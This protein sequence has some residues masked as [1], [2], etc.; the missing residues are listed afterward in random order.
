MSTFPPAMFSGRS[1]TVKLIVL[2]VL[3]VLL[4]IPAYL[5]T[6]L[7]NEREGRREEVLK[8]IHGSWSQRQS[9]VGPLLM[10]PYR[11]DSGESRGKVGYACFVPQKLDIGGTLQTE[12]RYRG[13]FQTTLYTADLKING[14]FSP[15]DLARLGVPETAI[16]WSQTTLVMGL[17]DLRGVKD[18]VTVTWGDQQLPME[19]GGAGDIPVGM[20][21]QVPGEMVRSAAGPTDFSLSLSLKGSQGLSLVPVGK[22]TTAALRSAWPAPSFRGNF[23]PDQRQ[24]TDAGFDATWKVLDVNSGIPAAWLAD[25]RGSSALA[26]TN[27]FGVDLPTMVDNYRNTL[28]TT[29][30]AVLFIVTLF[31]VFF[32]SE[33]F[34]G[35]R[36][37]PIQYLLAGCGVVMFYLLL[38]SLSEHIP[39]LW[40]YL[41]ASAAVVLLMAGYAQGSFHRVGITMTIAGTLSILY[42]YL[43]SLLQMEDYGLLIGSIGLF[44]ALAAIMYATRKVD[45]YKL[46]EIGPRAVAG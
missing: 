37:H 7:V 45:W 17:S 41:T 29:K 3:I 35:R 16:L 32:F 1:I 2:A 43:Y 46:E 44:V 30:Y 9:L 24:V 20:H 13:I 12:T 39:F 11:M 31:A 4:L 26:S 23:L 21:A 15:A 33:L 28:R 5:I 10:V 8:D 6:G 22:V 38:L 36:V 42:A 40:A 25:P 14:S 18:A 34:Y 19:A 27:A